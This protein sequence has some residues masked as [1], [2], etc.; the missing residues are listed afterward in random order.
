MQ[1]SKGALST[2]LPVLP[3]KPEIPYL[4][5]LQ[6]IQ[7]LKKSY[8]SLR[9]EFRDLKK[10]PGD[11]TLRDSVLNMAKAGSREVLEREGKVLWSLIESGDIAGEEVKNAARN[12]LDGVNHS[13]AR[14]KGISEVSDL[15]SLVDQN[16]ENLKALTN[17]WIMPKVEEQIT[18]MAKEGFDPRNGGIPDFYGK[19]ALAKLTKKGLPSEVPFEQ[20]KLLT[21][22]K[23]GHI[24]NEDFR[25][26]NNNQKPPRQ[27]RP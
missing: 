6:Q 10:M 13:K 26:N 11:S 15:E 16:K 12:T 27:I 8:D 23:T 18:G 20:A 5:E 4:E 24:T 1:F 2:R 25:T 21:Q 7:S 19:D 9:S 22:Q 17:E 3:T 14:L